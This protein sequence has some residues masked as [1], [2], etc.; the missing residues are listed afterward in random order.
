M[1]L[2]DINSE[3]VGKLVMYMNNI[4]IVTKTRPLPFMTS[5]LISI[6]TLKG[7]IIR[8]LMED[9]KFV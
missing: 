8:V 6:F 4:G 7:R 2:T 5:H 3:T 9:V 1:E